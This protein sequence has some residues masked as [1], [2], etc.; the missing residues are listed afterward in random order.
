[1]SK[2]ITSTVN[3][4]VVD[5]QEITN[6]INQALALGN[7]YP[8]KLKKLLSKEIP[9]QLWNENEE[10]FK[11]IGLYDAEDSKYRLLI[12]IGDLSYAIKENG[13]W[14]Y[15]G[16]IRS[17][18]RLTEKKVVFVTN[19]VIEWLMLD[20]L[21]LDYVFCNN[22][23]PDLDCNKLNC[24]KKI[25]VILPKL[26]GELCFTNIPGNL[27]EKRI[28][29][30][31]N[32]DTISDLQ[33]YAHE[34]KKEITNKEDFINS[35][36]KVVYDNACGRKEEV[37]S[38]V[39]EDDIY[40]SVYEKRIK[41][42][43]LLASDIKGKEWEFVCKGYLP[44][45]KNTVSMI[46]GSSGQGKTWLGLNIAIHLSMEGLKTLY[47]TKEDSAV[48]LKFRLD[49]L[50]NTRYKDVDKNKVV[51]LIWFLDSI[52]DK[53]DFNEDYFDAVILDPLLSFYF[54]HE[55]KDENNNVEAR[56]FINLF[57]SYASQ[58]QTTVLFLH[59]HNK[60]KDTRGASA[61]IDSARLLYQILEDN[62]STDTSTKIIQ[63]VKDTFGAK[64]LINKSKIPLRIMPD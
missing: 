9:Q 34:L 39:D 50:L 26:K 63:I 3:R 30:S 52:N 29:L 27:D 1:M 53:F 8:E 23:K 22:T 55:Y 36:Y 56:R 58:T 64:K 12:R 5:D 38:V 17:L 43:Y 15:Y 59:H 49:R 25:F 48:Y 16:A 40:T 20:W 18:W 11:N 61:F 35:L 21:G 57:I 60:N 6:T 62:K 19:N 10:S 41:Q 51:K 37:L 2:N 4:N 14:K 24:G 13:S 28:E 32:D 42:K 7:R 33:S 45:A 46:S 47:W 31:F 54:M 44:L